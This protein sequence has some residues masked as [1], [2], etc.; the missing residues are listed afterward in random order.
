MTEDNNPKPTASS[1]PVSTTYTQEVSPAGIFEPTPNPKPSK[2]RY[3]FTILGILQIACLAILILFV[4]WATQRY[5]AK[6]DI[7]GVE[8]IDLIVLV[9]LVP[10]IG[11][12]ALINFVGLP[13][14]MRRHKPQGKWLVLSIISLSVS[15]I[16]VLWVLYSLLG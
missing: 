16:V 13:L 1:P 3:F 2:W 8:F 5:Q 12:I 6:P 11:L 7:A 4:A 9:T 15:A 14:Y 10:A